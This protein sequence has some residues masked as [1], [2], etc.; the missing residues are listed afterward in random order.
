MRTPSHASSS[1]LPVLYLPSPPLPS[2]PQVL[3]HKATAD[4]ALDALEGQL[5]VTHSALVG[6]QLERR[7]EARKTTAA[8][9]L[10]R[11][12]VRVWG[13]GEGGDRGHA[14]DYVQRPAP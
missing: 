9:L 12:E 14:P 4:A 7:H 5:R 8:M 11:L 2:P 13:G 6:A 3:S 10:T 1:T